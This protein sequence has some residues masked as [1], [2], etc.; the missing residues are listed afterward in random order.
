MALLVSRRT[1]TR[2]THD[3]FHDEVDRPRVVR[4]ESVGD[5]DDAVAFASRDSDRHR[6]KENEGDEEEHYRGEIM[7]GG[8]KEQNKCSNRVVVRLALCL[9]VLGFAAI[10]VGAIQP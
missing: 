7:Y 6:K 8:V 9:F 5:P 1:P 3:I 2:F 10:A 4:Q